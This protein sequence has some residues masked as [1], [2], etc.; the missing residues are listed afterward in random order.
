MIEERKMKKI[1][2]PSWTEIIELL[3]ILVD[4]ADDDAKDWL[5]PWPTTERHKKS[6]QITNKL[7]INDFS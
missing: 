3:L 1:G 2:R 6:K 5:F 7:P 4:E